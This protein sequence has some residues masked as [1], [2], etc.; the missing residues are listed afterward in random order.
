MSDVVG[1]GWSAAPV[2]ALGLLAAPNAVVAG[3]SYLAGPGFAVGTGS[4]VSLV[5]TTHGTLPAFPVL[6]ALPTGHGASWPVWTLAAV[7]CLAAGAYAARGARRF[8]AG[9]GRWR[10]L[11]AAAGV[12]AL[13]GVVLAWL[14]GGSV[15]SAQLSAVGAS[16]WQ[17]GLALGV[18]VG[19]FGA[20]AML[21]ADV[22]GM[23]R[24][25]S[26]ETEQPLLAVVGDA[27]RSS[28]RTRGHSAD[29]TGS[30]GKDGDKL[31]G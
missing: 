23:V 13:A 21:V 2:L 28:G 18:Q 16:P 9:I 27:A 10:V 14:G 17:F 30:T 1:G 8:G 3:A 20:L 12:A 29:T 31:A 15:G 11:G 25:R 19:V 5:S 22:A 4:S 7:T 24:R 26:A 6:G